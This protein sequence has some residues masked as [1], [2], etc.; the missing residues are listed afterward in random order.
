MPLK[1]GYS[2]ATISHNIRKMMDEGYKQPQAVA[3]SLGNALEVFKRRHPRKKIPEHLR[4]T[5]WLK[6]H[7]KIKNPVKKKAVAKKRNPVI[8]GPVDH[9]IQ[10]IKMDGDGKKKIGYFDG[11]GFDT[12]PRVASRFHSKAQAEK[13]CKA[14]KKDLELKGPKWAIKVIKETELPEY[15]SYQR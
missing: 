9:L 15:K 12:S 8:R 1:Q 14:L 13:V 6:A 3:A 2:R 7:P 5:A 10:V 4:K 11:F